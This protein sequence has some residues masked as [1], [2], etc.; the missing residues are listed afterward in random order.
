MKVVSRFTENIFFSNLFI[1]FASAC[2]CFQTQ[3][4]L[5]IE[6]SLIPAVVM[7]FC[8]TLFE[9]TLH[10]IMSVKKA[11]KFF[12]LRSA[13]IWAVNKIKVLYAILAISGAGIVASFF[14]LSSLQRLFFCIAGVIT[15]AYTLPV[16]VFR[17][18]GVRLRDL[19]FLKIFLVSAVWA[20]VT[21]L[22]FAGLEQN[23]FVSQAEV[24]LYFIQR[25]LFIFAITIPFDIRD[26]S[27]DEK[28]GI[29]T[30]P[31]LYGAQKASRLS[32]LCVLFFIGVQLLFIFLH[33]KINSTDLAMLLSG[34]ITC[35]FLAS[36]KI[37]KARYYYYGVLD[38]SIIL[39]FLLIL[40]FARC[41][42]F[43]FNLF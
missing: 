34:V 39:Q 20:S 5:G 14:F 29:I 35:I 15:I 23:S 8:C 3:L 42:S 19:P 31:I 25:T 2:F 21:V 9:Y 40:F 27:L 26:S 10:R 22:P 11:H 16:V 6:L 13:E 36:E 32:Y 38:G 17:G 18:N 33:K 37:K 28:A 12:E 41:Y 1:A 43:S 7:V 4:F 24:W 30:L